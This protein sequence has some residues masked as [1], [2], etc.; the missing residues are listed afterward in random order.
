MG[1]DLRVIIFCWKRS[2]GS[3]SLS[4][5]RS[6]CSPRHQA[7]PITSLSQQWSMFPTNFN[8]P[9][10]TFRHRRKI[11]GSAIKL[12][13]GRS[14]NTAVCVLSRTAFFAAV[15]LYCGR[16]PTP[17]KNYLRKLCSLFLCIL[18][19]SGVGQHACIF[20]GASHFWATSW[21]FTSCCHASCGPS[22]SAVF[23][24]KKIVP[25]TKP[26]TSCLW[27]SFQVLIVNKGRH[28]LIR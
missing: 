27:S 7:P 3:I 17:I 25:A 5:L 22:V 16:N 26:L 1:F 19:F 12:S 20:S 9:A 4:W 18:A 2:D 24:A 8:P 10:D 21:H 14:V 23:A 13:R 28:V 11:N 15:M 6:I